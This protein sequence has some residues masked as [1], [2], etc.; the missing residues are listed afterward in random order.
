MWFYF[1][2]D[3]LTIVSILS[4]ESILLNPSAKRQEA[5]A[6]RKKF[7]SSEG[8]HITCLKIF[9]AFNAAKDKVKFYLKT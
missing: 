2:E 7:V 4:G 8:D 9:R 5:I 3:I 1:S 6:A